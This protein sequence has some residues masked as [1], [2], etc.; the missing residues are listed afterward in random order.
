MP[1]YLSDERIQ[2]Q[3]QNISSEEALEAAFLNM[4]TN[5]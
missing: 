1:N 3:I 2:T 4:Q 5:N